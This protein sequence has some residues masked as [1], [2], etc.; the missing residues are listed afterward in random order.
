MA[1]LQGRAHQVHITDALERV[2]HAAAR[3]LDDDVLDRF[4]IV[5]RVDRVRRPELFRELELVLV[6]VDR[7]DAAGFGH[8]GALDGADAGCYTAAEQANLLE[9]GFLADLGDGDLWQYRVLT[10]RGRSHVVVHG[11][12]IVGKAR[13]AVR[14][15]AL[16][17]RR[18]DGLAKIGL[19]RRAEIALATFRRVQ[20]DHVVPDGDRRNA[21]ADF[22]DDGAALVAEDRRENSLGVFTRQRERIGVADAG[23]DVAK[24]HFAGPGP[25]E[26]QHFDFQRF[27]RG[28]G[29]GSASFHRSPLVHFF[30][31]PWSHKFTRGS[32]V[33]AYPEAA[34]GQT[35]GR[36]EQT[37][38]CSRYRRR[39][40]ALELAT[41]RSA[42]GGTPCLPAVVAALHARRCAS[43][44]PHAALVEAQQRLQALVPAHAAQA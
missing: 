20:R 30:A 5:V 37:D 21:L 12:S 15:Q 43:L 32:C 39:P 14:H 29:N 25:L 36:Y 2:V 10:K 16:A 27:A 26:I 40:H 6:D 38:D 3:E 22:F 28:E 42:Q 18:P 33:P 11:I 41:G 1:A 9:R 4:V 17:L 34:L 8:D 23:S 13:R 44:E 24:Q 19:A 7:V 31:A 35:G